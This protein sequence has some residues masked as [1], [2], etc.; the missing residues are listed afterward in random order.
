MQRKGRLS[1]ADDQDI[2]LCQA[3]FSSGTGRQFDHRKARKSDHDAIARNVRSDLDYFA[4]ARD[5]DD[6]DWKAHPERMNTLAWRNHERGAAI[7]PV[8]AEQTAAP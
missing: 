2:R 1:Q 4:I 3:R 8:A 7:E 6:V 5:R